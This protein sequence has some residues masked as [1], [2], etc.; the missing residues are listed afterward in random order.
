MVRKLSAL[1]IEDFGHNSYRD[2]VQALVDDRK[3]NPSKAQ[4]QAL[5][6]EWKNRVDQYVNN[7]GSPVVVQLWPEAFPAK[8]TFLNLYSHP[9][10]NS[11]QISILGEL[12]KIRRLLN[13]CPCCGELGTPGTLDHYLPKDD[14]P[15]FSVIP[16]NLVPM[17]DICQGEKKTKVGNQQNPRFFIH[18]YFDNFL[19]DEL[20]KLEI[21][22]PFEHPHFTLV[23][24]KNLPAQDKAIVISHYKELNIHKRYNEFLETSYIKLL[25]AAD[26]IRKDHGNVKNRIK[27]FHKLAKLDGTNSWDSILYSSALENEDLLN[28]LQNED[29]P[30]YL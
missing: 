9:N 4:F 18:P 23:P 19:T 14:Y 10:E 2:Y 15:H 11:V 27:D 12:K 13:S 6:E 16:A 26:D 1:N 5:R 21:I 8:V 25:R 20:V 3:R 24:S 28:F 30:E 17:C 22:P 29:L 7:G